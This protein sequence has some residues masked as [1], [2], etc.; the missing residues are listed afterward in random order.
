M[1]WESRTSTISCVSLRAR[2]IMA[3]REA[4][5]RRNG[6]RAHW[7]KATLTRGVSLL[8][9]VVAAAAASM[10]QRAAAVVPWSHAS[11]VDSNGIRQTEFGAVTSLLPKMEKEIGG[12]PSTTTTQVPIHACMYTHMHTYTIYTHA[13]SYSITDFRKASVEMW[14]LIS[15][16]GSFCDMRVADLCNITSHHTTDFQH[17]NA[18][19]NVASHVL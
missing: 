13:Y 3:S 14:H 19:G 16:R 4:G 15:L 2:A 5:G 12:F 8:L 10:P 17:G 1:T 6:A 9:V 11:T 7:M 18:C